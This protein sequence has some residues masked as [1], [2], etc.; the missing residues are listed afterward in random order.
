MREIL[1]LK[2]REGYTDDVTKFHAFLDSQFEKTPSTYSDLYVASVSEKQDDLSQWRA[3]GGKQG[4]NGYS[5]GFDAM[6]LKTNYGVASNPFLGKVSY[7]EARHRQVCRRLLDVLFRFFQFGVEEKGTKQNNYLDVYGKIVY[8]WLEEYAFKWFPLMKDKS[9]GEEAEW[10]MV[11]QANRWD[12]YQSNS[13]EIPNLKFLARDRLIS[14]HIP[15]TYFRPDHNNTLLPI[16]VILVGP[17]RYQDIS[18][19]VS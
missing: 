5:I 12:I 2:S 19:R 14:L 8:R 18:R 16:R 4:E 13:W 11:Y 17:S 7:C 1:A 6:F 10:R 9:F 3:Y 15:Q